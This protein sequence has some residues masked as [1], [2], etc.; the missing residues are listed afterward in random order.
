MTNLALANDNLRRGNSGGDFIGTGGL[1][2]RDVY[3]MSSLIASISFPHVSLRCVQILHRRPAG[4]YIVVGAMPDVL[5]GTAHFNI[6]A[7]AVAMPQ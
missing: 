5:S 3:G 6:L 1:G 4:T 7:A 2:Y